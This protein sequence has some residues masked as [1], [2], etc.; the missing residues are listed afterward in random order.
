MRLCLPPYLL[1]VWSGEFQVPGNKSKFLL[2]QTLGIPLN[3]K[4]SHPLHC[5]CKRSQIDFLG[6]ARE[7]GLVEVGK[8]SSIG[9]PFRGDLACREAPGIPSWRVDCQTGSTT[10]W[11]LQVKATKGKNCGS[12]IF[13]KTVPGKSTQLENKGFSSSLWN[14]SAFI[15]RA[16][17]IFFFSSPGALS[18]QQCV[19][20]VIFRPFFS[21]F[22][23]RQ[24][25][26]LWCND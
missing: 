17:R 12:S 22:S 4:A 23:K 7:Q 5:S 8:Y 9:P 26:L 13:E 24:I 6:L 2:P 10:S 11:R 14:I 3:S 18:H 20:K 21:W 16:R 15:L 25:P 1:P 19:R